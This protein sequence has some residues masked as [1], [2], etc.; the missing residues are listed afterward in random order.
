MAATRATMSRFG[1]PEVDHPVELGVA[2]TAMAE[3]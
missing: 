1:A 3:P 2:A